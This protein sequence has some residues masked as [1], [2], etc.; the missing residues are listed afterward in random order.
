MDKSTPENEYVLII[1]SSNMDLN[2]YS[3]RLPSPGETVTGGIFRQSLGGK[4]ANQAVAAARAGSEVVFIAKIGR[5]DFGSQMSTKLSQEGINTNFMLQDPEEHSGVAFIM[6]DKN[7][8]NMIS[9]AP[10]ANAT[11]SVEEIEKHGSIL[12][13]AT[14]L[15]VQMEI[16]METI[17]KIYEI[18]SEGHC[19]KILN[20]AP[21]KPIPPDLLKNIDIIVPNEGE[22]FRLHSLLGFSNP[23]TKESISRSDNIIM[24]SKDIASLGVDYIITTLGADG[25][26]I[27]YADSDKITRVPAFKVNAV[28]TVGAGDCF[29]GVF[30]SYLTKSFSMIEAVKA[31]TAAASIAVTRKGAQES[32]PNESE[33]RQRIEEYN[34]IINL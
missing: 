22:L 30:V 8:E 32:M 2:I 11:L 25:S 21:L 18:A 15:V 28:D 16:P 20:P 13:N 4:G 6:I 5:D 12:R 23:Q 17:N 10:G 19:I 33:I 14:S 24:A 1:G 31:A 29:N 27:Y 7:G 3:E 9:V 26:L 34:K